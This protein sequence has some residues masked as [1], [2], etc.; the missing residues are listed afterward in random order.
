MATS[1]STAT[2]ERDPRSLAD[3]LRA[4]DD[5]SLATLF[6][7]RPELVVPVPPDMTV[8]SARATSRP[9]VLVAIESL[10]TLEIEVLELLTAIDEPMAAK[11]VARAVA[12]VPAG[13][14]RDTIER[15]RSLALVWGNDDD[16][17]VI[18]SVRELVTEPCG[19]GPPIA[20]AVIGLSTNR[21]RDVLQTLDLAPAAD[22]HTAT[23]RLRMW[24]S[25][26][27]VVRA[28]VA[29]APDDVRDL[30]ERL[31]WG[32]P[33]GTTETPARTPGVVWAI[34]RALLVPT[35]DRTVVLPREIGIALRRG[36]IVRGAHAT[37][38]EFHLHT[39]DPK[40]AAHTAA[41]HAAGFVRDMEN[42]LDLWST[43]PPAS[44]RTGG[45]RV[46]EVRRAAESLNLGEDHV[47]LL[48]EIAYAA[49]LLAHTTRDQWLPA[50]AYDGW[51]AA[52][53]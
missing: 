28:L 44:L 45:L 20:D 24:A 35:G 19:L 33:T 27:D 39:H 37:P 25:D 48:A 11:K 38:P 52:E 8:L 5:E 51:R 42:L 29:A 23:E 6:T 31:T 34:Q 41:A 2:E 7:E 14:V 40:S 26:G 50:P 43:D 21:L 32:P 10:T 9:S 17:H 36:V 22:R 18:R 53:D 30:L 4:M 12:D 3:W 1:R 13:V 49:G 46:R 15:L 16:L 47:V